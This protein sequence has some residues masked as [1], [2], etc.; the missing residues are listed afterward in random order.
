MASLSDLR[1]VVSDLLMWASCLQQ[2]EMSC[3][4]IGQDGW[5]SKE[6]LG[7]KKGGA[8][9]GGNYPTPISKF[10][11]SFW[12]EQLFYVGAEGGI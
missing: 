12:D 6:G 7:R 4:Y 1:Q 8:G 9:G 11:S 2:D 10:F 3:R 5:C